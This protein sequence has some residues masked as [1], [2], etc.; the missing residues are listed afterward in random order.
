MLTNKWAYVGLAVI[1]LLV[2]AAIFAPLL[3]P[4]DPA[5]ID[6]RNQLRKR[7]RLVVDRYDDGDGVQRLRRQDV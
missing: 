2:I 4:H 6:L 5:A 1:S 7:L 3:M